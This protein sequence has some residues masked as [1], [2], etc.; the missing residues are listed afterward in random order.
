MNERLK[1]L[2][3]PHSET[4]PVSFGTGSGEAR[5]ELIHFALYSAL[6]ARNVSNMNSGVDP[7]SNFIGV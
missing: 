7:V 3:Y 1:Y 2:H 4:S 5:L 6:L